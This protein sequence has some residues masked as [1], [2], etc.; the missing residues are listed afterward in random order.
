MWL[1]YSPV[2]GLGMPRRSRRGLLKCPWHV[3]GRRFSRRWWMRFAIWIAEN[4]CF[5]SNINGLAIQRICSPIIL[6]NKIHTENL[7]DLSTIL[8]FITDKVF[9][10]FLVGRGLPS[11]RIFVANHDHSAIQWIEM[12]L[13]IDQGLDLL[14]GLGRQATTKNLWGGSPVTSLVGQCTE[15]RDK[16]KKTITWHAG[17]TQRRATFIREVEDVVGQTTPE[18]GQV[19]SYDI[20]PLKKDTL[21]R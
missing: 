14:V 10:K 20:R 2:H 9:F 17:Y 13:H 5:L 18:Y 8:G 11:R 1:R 16:T 21:W 3:C 12:A 7:K 15:K 6:V 4:P 19:A